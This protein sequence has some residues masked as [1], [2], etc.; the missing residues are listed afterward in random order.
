MGP[1]QRQQL[2]IPVLAFDNCVKDYFVK[3][4][5]LASLTVKRNANSSISLNENLQ[6][7]HKFDGISND[8]VYTRVYKLKF[9]CDFEL[10]DYPFDRQTCF[11]IV[12]QPT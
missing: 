3:M 5:D 10:H 4:D 2:W 1:I 12:S 8:L 11:I 7:E 9:A 6:E